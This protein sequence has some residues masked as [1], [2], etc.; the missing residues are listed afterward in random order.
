[1]VPPANHRRNKMLTHLTL[2]L[3]LMVVLDV[4]VKVV[5]RFR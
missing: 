2:L 4:K 5:I 3:I 1:M